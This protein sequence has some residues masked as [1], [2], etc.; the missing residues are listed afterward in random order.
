MRENVPTDD[1]FD[2][3]HPTFE[4]SRCPQLYDAQTD[5]HSGCSGPHEPNDQTVPGC[6]SQSAWR[7]LSLDIGSRL[8]VR[9][10]LTPD[11]SVFPS[12]AVLCALLV[13]LCSCARPVSVLLVGSRF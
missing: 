9:M 10:V 4:E 7:A 6:G 2:Q 3:A 5:A 12:G 11:C 13:L 8:T 1:S